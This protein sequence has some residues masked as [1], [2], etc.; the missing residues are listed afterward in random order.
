MQ[1]L[2]LAT[3]IFGVSF[4]N[5]I[6][7]PYTQKTHGKGSYTFGLLLSLSALLFFVITSK[8][9]DFNT[10]LI[11]YSA[12]FAL[13]YIL[14]TVFALEAISCGSLSLTALLISYSLL[15]PTVYGLVFLKDTV[16]RWFIP[17]FILLVISLFLTNAKSEKVRINFKWVIF[18]TL[19]SIGNG[20]CSVSQKMQQVR[21][22]GAHKNEFMILALSI[23]ATFLLVYSLIK[24]RRQMTGF[25]KAGWKESILCGLANGVVNML[26]MVLSDTMPA[27][28]LFPLISG[29]GILITHLVARF[30]YKEKL[31][32]MQ[33][34]GFM[35]GLASVILL[36]L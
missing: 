4:Q 22:E 12:L 8:G 18:A 6:K 31:S 14:G 34:V 3:V 11:P 32:K 29:G 36:N 26:V 20:M 28:L 5:I 21:F 19:A 24:E 25:I 15:L 33:T 27:S 23:V 2:Y 1:Y 10:G 7:K 35:I 30:Y 13:S 16:G 9:L 17:G